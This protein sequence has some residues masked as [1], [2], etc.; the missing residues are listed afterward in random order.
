[1]W[2]EGGSE[3]GCVLVVGMEARFAAQL[4]CLCAEDFDSEGAFCISSTAPQHES[5][6]LLELEAVVQM[7]ELLARHTVDKAA[8]KLA[9]SMHA[10]LRD[11]HEKLSAENGSEEGW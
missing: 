7:A 11:V 8:C 1:M 3:G 5:P 6:H 10:R 4:A 2:E 9:P